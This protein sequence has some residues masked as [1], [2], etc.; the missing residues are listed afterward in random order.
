LAFGYFIQKSLALTTKEI[1]KRSFYVLMISLTAIVISLTPTAFML[2]EMGPA[3]AL[4]V[5]TLIFT[6]T[7]AVLF[8]YIG[9]AIKRESVINKISIAAISISAIGM[10]YVNIRVYS[11]DRLFTSAYDQRMEKI[12]ELNKAGFSGIAEFQPLPPTAM[13]YHAEFSEDT[14]YF[15]NQHWKKGLDLKYNVVISH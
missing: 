2:G 14:T 4:S 11:T 8:T 5:I 9:M 15:V 6:I 13:L 10:I 12:L 3:R 7:S 1:W